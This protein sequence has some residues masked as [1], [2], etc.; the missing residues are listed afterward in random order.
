MN[1]IDQLFFE[2][3]ERRKKAF[4]AFITAGDPSLKA[5]E[6]LALAFEKSGVTSIKRRRCHLEDIK[7]FLGPVQF[8]T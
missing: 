8:L 3:D 6:D 1:R 7:R 4:I 2:L 5:T